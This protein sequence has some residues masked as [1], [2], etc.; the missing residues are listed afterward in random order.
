MLLCVCYLCVTAIA[1]SGR[2]DGAGGH[3]DRST[4]KYHYHHGYSAHQHYDMDGDG[5][6]D[7]PYTFDHDSMSEV[8]G[9]TNEEKHENSANVDKS[10]WEI[11]GDIFVCLFITLAIF[12]FVLMLLGLTAL[13]PKKLSSKL[14]D[15]LILVYVISFI[16][17]WIVL[18]FSF[19]W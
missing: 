10:F 13:L 14:E 12:P 3:Y 17:T 11:C 2:T 19:D 6:K 8:E 15:H 18:Y 1:H 4:G 7:C 16:V 5:D 9:E